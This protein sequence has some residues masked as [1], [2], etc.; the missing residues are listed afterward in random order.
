MRLFVEHQ[1]KAVVVNLNDAFGVRI[2][3]TLQ[4]AGSESASVVYGYAITEDGMA[5]NGFND[6]SDS[7]K[8]LIASSA[9]FNHLGLSADI[10]YLGQDYHLKAAV[11]ADFNLSNL[12]AAIGTLIALGTEPAEAVAM[13]SKVETVPGRIEKVKVFNDDA[14]AEFLTVVDYA[15]TPGALESVLKALRAHC[16]GRLICVFGCG[17]DRDKGKRPLM[18]SAAERLAEAVIVTDDNPRFEDAK[19]ITK[20]IL[21]GFDKPESV[22]V[23]NDRAKA[24][25]HAVA[26][27]KS[28]D[29]V[30]VAGKGHE[31]FQ[32]VQG[33][34][35]PF[36][37]GEEIRAALSELAKRAVA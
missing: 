22:I 33:Q 25:R 32:L 29:V 7:T 6:A 26:M 12:L 27:A 4:Q 14:E 19:Q 15:H 24:I 9:Q 2:A 18:A 5:P 1:P 30:L 34:E 20:E 3:E 31:K 35:L 17:G 36:D 37:D 16:T 13:V 8:T 11:L 23:L 21:S 28:G 10:S